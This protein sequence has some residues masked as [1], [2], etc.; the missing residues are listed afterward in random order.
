MTNPDSERRAVRA[1]ADGLC[2]FEA[3]CGLI[4]NTDGSTSMISLASSARRPWLPA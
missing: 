4:V 2:A 3:D 1:D